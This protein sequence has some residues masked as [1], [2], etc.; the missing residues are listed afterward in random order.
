[1]NYDWKA[2]ELA[3]TYNRTEP[4]GPSITRSSDL[5]KFIR[6][7]YEP[8]IEVREKFFVI[9]VSMGLPRVPRPSVKVHES[10][11]LVSAK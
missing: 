1:M 3:L 7:L 4:D 6:P 8:D 11:V 10:H 2:G 5:V 9:G